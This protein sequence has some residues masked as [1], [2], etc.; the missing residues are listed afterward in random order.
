[1]VADFGEISASP[2]LGEAGCQDP[3]HR[4]A[5]DLKAAGDCGFADS[6]AVQLECP[7]AAR[8]PLTSAQGI[9]KSYRNG[10]LLVMGART[11]A[12]RLSRIFELAGIEGGYAHRFR[13][14]FAVELLLAG[15]PLERIF[16]LL[17]HSRTKVTENY[18]APWVKARQDQLES[19]VRKSWDRDPLLKE[20]GQKATVVLPFRP[21]KRE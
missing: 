19:A 16:I 7:E 11:Y 14:T 12:K 5:A 10:R 8:P 3:A 21:R 6:G 2:S 17:G 20:E 1:M 18:Y 4:G 13:D 9:A 15:E